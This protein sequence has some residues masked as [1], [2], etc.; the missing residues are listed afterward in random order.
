MSSDWDEYAADWDSNADV[1]LYSEKAFQSL[2]SIVSLEGL[3]ILDF[4]CGTGLLTERMSKYAGNVVGLDTS[5]EMLAV[6]RRKRLSNV[7]TI[8]EELSENLIKNSSLLHSKFD[9]VVASS[10]CGFVT[11][12]LGT[13]L[14]L[15]S[16][17]LSGGLLVQ[18]DWLSMGEKS[19]FGLSEEK[20][21]DAFNKTGLEM[22]SISLPFSLSST[23][24]NMSVLMGV[25]KN[26]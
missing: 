5:S 21:L 18:W 6:L 16:L 12:Y 26:T 22:V 20:I 9:L 1:V 15:K 10:V 13:L 14:L 4:G 2:T 25:G 17:L 11:D 8:G 7:N 3:N 19:K 24:G 23:D